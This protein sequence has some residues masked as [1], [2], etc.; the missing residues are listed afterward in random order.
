MQSITKK[1]FFRLLEAGESARIGSPN[2]PGKMEVSD[3]LIKELSHKSESLKFRKVV[4]RQTNAIMFDN[5]SWFF[6]DKPKN[7][8]SRKCFKTEIDDKTYIILVDHRP[9]YV[10]PFGTKIS[11]KTMFLIYQLVV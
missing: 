11:E 7:C 8:D 1:E 3:N 9:A 2:Y 4:Y 5:K 10:N 6:F